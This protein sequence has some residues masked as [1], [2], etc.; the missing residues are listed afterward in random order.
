MKRRAARSG[1]ASPVTRTSAWA[2]KRKSPP[3]T[4]TTFH[5]MGTPMGMLLVMKRWKS[6]ITASAARVTGPPSPRRSATG[7]TSSTTVPP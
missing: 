5:S 6:S 2:P 7:K 1:E 4:M 3:Y